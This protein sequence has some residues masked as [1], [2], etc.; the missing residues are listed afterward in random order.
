M[1]LNRSKEAIEYMKRG[2]AISE[3]SGEMNYIL[4]FNIHLGETYLFMK[5]YSQSGEYFNKALSVSKRV[6]SHINIARTMG[7]LGSL[8]FYLGDY[9]RSMEYLTDEVKICVDT[10]YTIEL[11]T[12]L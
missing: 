4:Q 12:A 9:D 11:H 1:M 3:E 2:L 6:G 5:Q 7:A 10:D 8:C